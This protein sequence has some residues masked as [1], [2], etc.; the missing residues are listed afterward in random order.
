[1][2]CMQTFSV[3]LGSQSL[4]SHLG[5]Q[6]SSNKML[7]TVRFWSYVVANCFPVG[8][9]AQFFWRYA[10]LARR[11][12]ARWL[13]TGFMLHQLSRLAMLSSVLSQESEAFNVY[14]SLWQPLTRL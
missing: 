6:R 1:M 7:I 3:L 5:I 4:D 9:R 8:R 2:N 10:F 14:I 13:P 12:W 11:K